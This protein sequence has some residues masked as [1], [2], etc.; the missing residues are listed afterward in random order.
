MLTVDLD[1]L[2]LI[3]S[4]PESGPPVWRQVG[5]V[6]FDLVG[7]GDSRGEGVPGQWQTRL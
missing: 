1:H 6:E 4:H 2:T 3:H 7:D 5:V